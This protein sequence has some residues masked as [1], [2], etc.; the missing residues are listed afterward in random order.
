MGGSG[1]RID[2]DALEDIDRRLASTEQSLK[3][4]HAKQQELTDFHRLLRKFYLTVETKGELSKHLKST[5]FRL[6][7]DYVELIQYRKKVSE[8]R[9]YVAKK[10]AAMK[11]N[12]LVNIKE[13]PDE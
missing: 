12:R 3:N 9:Y 10:L 5:N 2:D 4:L 11:S 6:F 1:M 7:S 8:E 13:K